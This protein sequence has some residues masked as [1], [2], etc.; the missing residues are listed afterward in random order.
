MAARIKPEI[1]I[2]IIQQLAC[3]DPPSIVADA[4]KDE[5]GFVVTRQYVQ[6]LDPTK[7]V[8]RNLAKKW[9]T[10]FETT[11]EEFL[12]ESASVS[13]SHKPVR[14]R[15]LERMAQ[16]AESMGNMVLTA[17]LLEQA[18]KECGDFHVRK[19]TD[20][21]DGDIAGALRELAKELPV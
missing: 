21:G 8:G 5:F 3:F 16:K 20:S 19:Q 17:Q 4:V 15:A 2:F 6:T 14:L 1:K 18:S 13:I 7:Y 12:K 11:R 9:R 10:V